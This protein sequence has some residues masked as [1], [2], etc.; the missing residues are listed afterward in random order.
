[1]RRLALATAA[2]TLLSAS[3]ATRAPTPPGLDFFV[4]APASD[5]WNPKINDWQARHG[6]DA[7]QRAVVGG[8]Q[9]R[10]GSELGERYLEFVS[11]VEQ[12][13]GAGELRDRI[14]S[15]LVTWVQ[16]QS[17]EYYRADGSEDH[18]A[19]LGHVIDRGEDDCDGLDLLTFVLLRR[20][21][22]GPREI[23]RAIIVE[24]DTG[25]HHMVT[26]WFDADSPAAAAADPWVLDP[27]G[28]VR[29]QMTRLSEIQG[30]EPIELFDESAHFRVVVGPVPTFV[31]GN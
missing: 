10:V 29:A 7:A 22:F 21:G 20:L 1:V 17:H 13:L 3:C 9:P 27:T 5:P 11:N 31:A 26:L 28:V 24:R 16:T 15:D 25:Q 14:A 12:R 30:W 6:L 2:V 8:E 23:Y 19:T 4:P 18:W